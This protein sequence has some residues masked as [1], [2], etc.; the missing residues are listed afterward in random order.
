M[1]PVEMLLGQL[2]EVADVLLEGGVVDQHVEP[3]ELLDRPLHRVLAEFRIGDV[4]R[5]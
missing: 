5:Q 4:A 2:L 1:R 3:A